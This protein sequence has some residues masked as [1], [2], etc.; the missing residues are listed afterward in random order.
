MKVSIII[1][2]YNER[3]TIEKIIQKILIIDKFLIEL[4]VIDDCSQDGSYEILKKFESS[5]ILKKNI[6]N[7]GKGFCVREGI[8]ISTGDIILIQDADLEYSPDDYP[9]LINPIIENIAD[10]VYGSRFTSGGL[11]RVLFFWHTIGNKFLTLLSNFF[12]NLNLTDMEIGYKVF[13]SDIL[14]KIELKENRFG[15][16]PEVTAKIS[17]IKNIRIYE[18]GVQYHG[19][20]YSEGKKISWID[21]IAAI[22]CILRYNIFK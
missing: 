4:I 12:T 15:F 13:K 5:I 21:G 22:W 16:E 17:K 8:K 3:L 20:K 11:T 9:K 6:K 1:P 18:V 19:R 7:M 10:I 14:K 2:C